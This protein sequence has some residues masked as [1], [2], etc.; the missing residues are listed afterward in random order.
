MTTDSLQ[1]GSEFIGLLNKWIS[2]REEMLQS[3]SLL[4]SEVRYIKEQIAVF[5]AQKENIEA[6][7]RE[8]INKTTEIGRL[9]CGNTV[10]SLYEIMSSDWVVLN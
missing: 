1:T 6:L 7:A 3:N 9:R 5:K 10:Y 4:P 8:V 2:S